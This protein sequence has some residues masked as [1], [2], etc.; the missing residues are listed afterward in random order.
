MLKL[1]VF[2]IVTVVIELFILYSQR[3]KQPSVTEDP[4]ALSYKA[5]R[6]DEPGFNYIPGRQTWDD[7][8]KRYV[9]DWKYEWEYQGEKHS[10][11]V[12]NNPNSQ[13]E[14]YMSSFPDEI[15]ITIHKETGK[16]YVS[17]VQRAQSRQSLWTLL[18]SLLLGWIVT[19]MLIR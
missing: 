14:H 1:F 17:K 9:I 5:Y 11:M 12:C 4:M 18:L 19:N 15:N 7:K 8:S 6:V 16:H 2:V 10:I 3:N 13:Y